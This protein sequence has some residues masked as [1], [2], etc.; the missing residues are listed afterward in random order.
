MARALQ[1]KGSLNSDLQDRALDTRPQLYAGVPILPQAMSHQEAWLARGVYRVLR[2][3]HGVP[4]RTDSGTV[5][6]DPLA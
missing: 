3:V 4:D 2:A 5:Q 1:R 6:T